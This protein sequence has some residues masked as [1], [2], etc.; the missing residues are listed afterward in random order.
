[1]SQTILRA[2]ERFGVRNQDAKLYL[3]CLKQPDGLFVAD[4]VRLTGMKRSSINVALPRLLKQR[5]LT[6]VLDGRRY[7]Y[8]AEPPDHVI[9]T[10][11]A[12]LNDFKELIPTLI[13]TTD[14][15]QTTRLYFYPNR[16]GLYEVYEDILRSCKTLHGKERGF[17]SFS[18]GQDVLR[19]LPDLQTVFIDRRIRAKIFIQIIAANWAKRLKA[20]QTDPA[21]LRQVKYFDQQHFPVRVE[22]NVYGDKIAFLNTVKPYGAIIIHNAAIA[23]AM[24]ALFQLLWKSLAEH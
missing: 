1:M 12:Q 4:M 15:L 11:A 24:R 21:A 17:Y 8:Q 14:D 7:R 9:K 3:A 5:W 20:W 16:E 6:R 19:T 23:G 13:R 22:V 10:L 2:L 18:S